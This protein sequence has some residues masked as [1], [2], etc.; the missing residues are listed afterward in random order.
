VSRRWWDGVDEPIARATT[1]FRT[2]CPKCRRVLDSEADIKKVSGDHANGAGSNEH[3]ARDGSCLDRG[4]DR[5]GR[6]NTR[7]GAE[8]SA[9]N[10]RAAG[11]AR[12]CSDQVTYQ[13]QPTDG[14]SLAIAIAVAGTIAVLVACWGIRWGDRY[15]ER[16]NR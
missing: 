12:S 5:M 15:W 6:N 4:V 7:D 9:A 13:T 8:A 1:A 11:R 16:R 10:D 2:T 3:Q 14:S